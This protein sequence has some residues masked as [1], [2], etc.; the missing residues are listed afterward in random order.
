VD[1]GLCRA[2]YN[3]LAP[4]LTERARRIWAATEARAAGWGGITGVARATGISYSTI[5]RGLKE[6][7]A[8]E[9]LAPDR[10]RRPGGGRKRTLDKDPTLLADLEGLG[11]PPAS[12]DPMSPLR[13]TSKSVRHLAAELQ[14]LGHQVSRQLV[15]ELLAAAGYSLQANRKTR[16][17]PSHP[18]RDAQFRYLNQRVRRFQA[19]T[20]PVISVDTKKKELVGDFKNAGRQWRPRG[21]P[22][23]VR[24][25][26][27]LIP[28]RGK[29]IPYGVYDL[30]RNAGWVSVGVDHDTATFAVRTIGRW[31]RTMGR[32]RYR[33]A[34]S[35][36]ITADAGGSK[37]PRGRLWKW[38]LQRLAARAGLT[39]PVCHLPPGTRK[40]NKSN[41]DS[42]RTSAPIGAASPW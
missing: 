26:D 1:V 38:D 24:V 34:R 40:W 23:P 7:A 36:L 42:S 25:H 39:I 13:W 6:L 11:E 20:Q 31:W 14:R 10:I 5:Q 28:A 29:A 30:T 16:E 18:D 2:K 12:G 4:T 27:F 3:A 35:L 9:P 15:S 33:R 17:G 37:G 21:Q 19:T 8:N 41:T 32:P 22:V